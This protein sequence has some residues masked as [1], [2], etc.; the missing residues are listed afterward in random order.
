MLPTNHK[1]Q[2]YGLL[3]GTGRSLTDQLQGQFQ[4]DQTLFLS[5][6]HTYTCENQREMETMVLHSLQRTDTVSAI[7]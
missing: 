6:T 4:T 5:L 3:V 1:Y 2:S 7:E